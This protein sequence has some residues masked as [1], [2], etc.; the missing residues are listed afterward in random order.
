MKLILLYKT[1]V[2]FAIASVQKMETRQNEGLYNVTMQ[3]NG[4]SR[5][6]AILA[7]ANQ[8][9]SFEMFGLNDIHLNPP[10]QKLLLEPRPHYFLQFIQ[11]ANPR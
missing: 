10:E 1:K 3:I 9:I 6:V 5:I 8:S 4:P 2:E 7:P 11:G